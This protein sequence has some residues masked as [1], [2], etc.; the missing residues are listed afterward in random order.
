[1]YAEERQ[2]HIQAAVR[3]N[4]KVDVSSLAADL[5]V[6]GETIRRDLIA[7]ERRGVL[8]RTHGGAISVERLGFEPAPATR[9]LAMV[10]EKDAIAKRAV[11]ELPEE[12]AILLDSGSTI[13]AFVGAFPTDIRLTV[14]T[15]SL[16]VALAVT[17]FPGITLMLL[18]GRW[19]PAGG[20]TVD[21]W[22]LENLSHI[23][24]DVAFVGTNG[25]STRRGLTTTDQSEAAVKSAMIGAAHRVVVLADHSKVGADYF[26]KVADLS[27]IDLVITDGG[28]D[29]ELAEDLR[30]AGPHL[31]IA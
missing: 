17:A 8:Q 27:T 13:E 15:H 18:G 2:H 14:V 3:R 22:A 31:D 9:E 29:P 12:G 26:Y 16:H 24:A 7:L 23:V 20:C 11:H 25:L 21:R 28:I 19:R 30:I 10:A 5:D 1:M 6:T 4:G